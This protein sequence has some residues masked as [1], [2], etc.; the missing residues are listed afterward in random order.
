MPLGALMDGKGRG[1]VDQ[2]TLI[3]ETGETTAKLDATRVI[4]SPHQCFAFDNGPEDRACL[5]ILAEFLARQPGLAVCGVGP[6]LS[7]LLLHQPGLAQNIR[8][9]LAEPNSDQ[10]AAQGIPVY[11]LDSPPAGIQTVFLAETRTFPRMQMRRRLP[12]HL[13]VIEPNILGEIAA[14]S[15]PV[16]SWTPIAKNIYPINVPEIRFEAGLDMILTD[17]PA[18][19]LALMPNG[20]GYVHNALKAA[21]IRFQTFDLDIV[22]YHR[23]HI[24]RL[25]DEGGKVILSDGR[26]LPVDPWQA[27]HYDLWSD[28]L[29]LDRFRPIIHEAAMAIIEANPKVLGLSVHQCNETF[30]RELIQ[31]IKAV[32]P[33]MMVVVGGFSCYNPEVGRVGFPDCDYMCIGE[34]DLTVGSLVESLARG[35]RPRNV[36]GVLSRFDTP[37][38]RFIPAPMPHNLE[39]LPFP[40]YEWF[41]LSIYRNFNDYQLVPIIAS[42]GCRWSRCTFCAERFYWRI[43]PE[44]DFVNELE[45]LSDQ[46]CHL[47]MFNESDLNGNPEKLLAICDEIIRRDLNIKL[48]GQLRIHKKSDRAFFD[49]LRAAGFVALRFGVDAFSEN[50]LRLQ[51]K[52]YTTET[53]SQNLKDCWEAGIFTE[54]NWVIG[55]PGETDDDVQEGIDLILKNSPYIGRLANINPLILVQGSVYWID[56]ESHNIVFRRSREEIYRVNPRVVPADMWYSTHPYIDATVRRQRFERIV[57]SLCDAGFQ[58]GAWATRVID[59]VQSARDRNRAGLRL[60]GD[61]A[62]NA[63]GSATPVTLRSL[64]NYDIVQYCGRFYGVPQQMTS[65]NFA[66]LEEAPPVDVIVA[67]SENN[68]AL[69]IEKFIAEQY[70][71]LAAI[72]DRKAA[73]QGVEMRLDAP[74]D[75]SQPRLMRAIGSIN[76]VRYRGRYY[77]VP[78]TLGSVDVTTEPLPKGV[79]VADSPVGLIT[80]LD[81]ASRWANSRGVFDA[82]EAQ[83]RGGSAYRVA[84]FLGEP[85]LSIVQSDFILLESDG[86]TFTTSRSALEGIA[87]DQKGVKI[88]ATITK[89]STPE[90]IR[91]FPTKSCNVVSFD[92]RFYAIPFGL[93][94]AW[95][96]EDITS[97][98]GVKVAQTLKALLDAIGYVRLQ[99]SDASADIVVAVPVI[100]TA[101]SPRLVKTVQAYNIVE[102]EGWVYGIPQALGAMDL[103]EVD[104]TSLSGVVRDVSADV[105]ESEILDRERVRLAA[106]G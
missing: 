54:V 91:A 103:T 38:Y 62:V 13:S 76:V 80:E 41:D 64:H 59:D 71:P 18:R 21:E 88:A 46:G 60:S 39:Q 104:V 69:L 24:S 86:E 98:P 25:F 83:R 90:L 49:R 20:L 97:K 102:Y 70:T 93:P 89:G 11:P 36:P 95:G 1:K 28:P 55:V 66:E 48:T 85:S 61:A 75:D 47:F 2:V 82:Q 84:S 100:N 53:I 30:S 101:R 31:L 63:G 58:V 45:W 81:Y 50:T 99:G 105:V 56:P 27:E 40:R 26:Q 29:V 94:V 35:E 7:Y 19:N 5:G 3:V 32:R 92:S 78:Q 9:V 8:A 57:L 68:C 73:V 34:A 106:A 16:R 87:P 77:G 44:V 33:D 42:R 14:G 67:F 15:V 37:D 23:F 79:V 6:F 12:S 74:V 43:R 72:M 96:E 22:C 4:F 52:G 17:C 51:K 65:R 10:G